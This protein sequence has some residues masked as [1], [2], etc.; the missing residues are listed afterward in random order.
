M[1]LADTSRRGAA[2]N[3]RL[4][5]KGIQNGS[6]FREALRWRRAFSSGMFMGPPRRRASGEAVQKLLIRVAIIEPRGVMHPAGICLRR[7]QALIL[8]SPTRYL[9][10]R[11]AASIPQELRW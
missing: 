4:A 11:P 3:W 5:V 2:L 9:A 7:G 8:R 10:M 1:S 6:R